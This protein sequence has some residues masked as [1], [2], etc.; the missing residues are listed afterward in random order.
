MKPYNLG[1]GK[2]VFPVKH[3]FLKQ[4]VPRVLLLMLVIVSVARSSSP[5][6][7]YSDL[8][9]AA[10]TASHS[11]AGNPAAITIPNGSRSV[12]VD[13]NCSLKEYQ[14]AVGLSFIDG[15]GTTGTV[16]LKTRGA[17]LYICMV[18]AVGSYPGRFASIYID[19][20]FGREAYP[21]SDDLSLR[22][23]FPGP[24]YS[25][26]GADSPGAYQ[27]VSLSG[28]NAATSVTTMDQ[29]EY[30]VPVSFTGCGG[31][32]GLAVYHHWFSAPA[33]DYGWPQSQYWDVPSTWAA[34]QLPASSAPTCTYLPLI[35]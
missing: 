4:K 30:Q 5:V 22:V 11:L 32:F 25:L 3:S 13:G 19:P 31:T 15:N 23:G 24:T 16:Y 12:K 21:H 8:P 28:W 20:D 2:T 7:A 9:G 6:F 33:D 27:S 18:G 1:G 17:Y 29:A 10:A 35:Q 14:D 26:Q 34:V